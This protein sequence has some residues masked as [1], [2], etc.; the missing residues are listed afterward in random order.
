MT[1][2]GL[3]NLVQLGRRDDATKVARAMRWREVYKA[4]SAAERLLFKVPFDD[5]DRDRFSNLLNEYQHQMLEICALPTERRL[6]DEVALAFRE[7]TTYRRFA[8][9]MYEVVQRPGTPSPIYG[10]AMFLPELSAA[11]NTNDDWWTP[12]DERYKALLEINQLGLVTWDAQEDVSD[13]GC[14][15]LCFLAEHWAREAL[16]SLLLAENMYVILGVGSDGCG[17]RTPSSGTQ[18]EFA[19]T[20]IALSYVTMP[21]TDLLCSPSLMD[22]DAI[23]ETLN[24]AMWALL[25]SSI[26]PIK[27]VDKER[28]LSPGDPRGLFNRVLRAWQGVRL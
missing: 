23:E 16:C 13:G 14:A 8:E 18:A 21:G 27:V 22:V 9:L 11:G 10:Y 28:G 25:L 26:T 7:C 5:P 4:V 19:R 20:G 3:P 17:G 24:P 6:R 15:S 12:D 1:D 2:S